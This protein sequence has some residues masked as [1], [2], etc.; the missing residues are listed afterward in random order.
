MPGTD[1]PALVRRGA[2]TDTS[3]RS[4]PRRRRV[5]DVLARQERRRARDDRRRHRRRSDNCAIS[6][7]Y[8]D[9]ARASSPI[10]ADSRRPIARSSSRTAKPIYWL[11]GSIHSPETGSPEML[12]ELAYRLAVDESRFV[13]G[14][15]RQRHHADHAG[16]RSR[17]TRSRGRRRQGI[18]R[19]QARQRRACRSSTGASTPRTTTIATAW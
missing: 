8:R 4:L 3:T 14:Y 13:Q 12:M 11:S 9:A 15:P 10:R 7:D 5:E 6:S 18:A 16:H 1:R 2:S 19:A 17:R